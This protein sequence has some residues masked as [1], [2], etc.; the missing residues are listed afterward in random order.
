MRA[1]LNDRCIRFPFAQP[2]AAHLNVDTRISDRALNLGMT[3]HVILPGS[4][5]RHYLV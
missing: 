5:A 1:S 2:E 4:S 3:E